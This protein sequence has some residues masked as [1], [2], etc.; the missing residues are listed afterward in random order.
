[1]QAPTDTH[2]VLVR[3]LPSGELLEM[4]ASTSWRERRQWILATAVTGVDQ[5][6]S[7]TQVTVTLTAGLLPT[8]GAWVHA[9]MGTRPADNDI[10]LR[11]MLIQDTTWSA[12][13]A[14]LP[15][16]LSQHL[17]P[18][19]VHGVLPGIRAILDRWN[20]SVQVRTTSHA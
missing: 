1:M 16:A 11:S 20:T 7:T 2:L 13:T 12:I 15:H 10:V 5:V 18:S 9:E 3:I 19:L 6:P 4:P 14:A 8:G 17:S